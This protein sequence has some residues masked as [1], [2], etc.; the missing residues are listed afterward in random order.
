MFF[1]SVVAIIVAGAG[2]ATLLGE[3]VWLIAGSGVDTTDATDATT[4]VQSLLHQ[5]RLDLYWRY[6]SP[7]IFY[8]AT[9]YL[10]C[11]LAAYRLSPDLSKQ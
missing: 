10:S 11:H 7:L 6:D 9:G 2:S 8:V 1:E 3:R 4:G 5:L